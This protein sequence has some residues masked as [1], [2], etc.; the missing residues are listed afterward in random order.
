VHNGKFKPAQR[1]GLASL[2]G[3]FSPR[4]VRVDTKIPKVLVRGVLVSPTTTTSINKE[5]HHKW[6]DPNSNKNLLHLLHLFK[7]I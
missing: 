2:N 4:S 3:K 6:V 7:V 1:L 5:A